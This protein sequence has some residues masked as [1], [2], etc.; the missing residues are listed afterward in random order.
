MGTIRF[1]EAAVANSALL[2]KTQHRE[3]WEGDEC[4]TESQQI[5]LLIRSILKRGDYSWTGVV[6]TVD[7]ILWCSKK[8]Y[9]YIHLVVLLHAGRLDVPLFCIW[10]PYYQ[11]KLSRY[12]WNRKWDFENCV[13]FLCSTVRPDSLQ[14]YEN[15]SFFIWQCSGYCF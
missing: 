5:P 6:Q 8:I 7:F 1:K 11:I 2:C 12:I 9:I 4:P 3:S 10:E 14:R 15:S 13:V